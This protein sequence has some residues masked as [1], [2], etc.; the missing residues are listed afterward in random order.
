MVYSDSV[1]LIKCHSRITAGILL[2]YYDIKLSNPSIL[3]SAIFQLLLPITVHSYLPP[4]NDKKYG[5]K[6]QSKMS[7][8]L[9]NNHDRPEKELHTMKLEGRKKMT[10]NRFKFYE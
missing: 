10:V 9:K 4:D 8:H 7:S 3:P 2:T 1:I 6:F 5:S